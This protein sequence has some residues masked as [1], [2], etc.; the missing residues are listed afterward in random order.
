MQLTNF[1]DVP[2]FTS[3]ALD[4]TL[5]HLISCFRDDADPIKN[6]TEY[7][8]HSL[9]SIIQTESIP[10]ITIFLNGKLIMEKQRVY[11]FVG[12]DFYETASIEDAE[13]IVER[14]LFYVCRAQ[15][16]LNHFK[17]DVAKDIVGIIEGEIPT[18]VAAKLNM[19]KLNMSSFSKV[20]L[21]SFVRLYLLRRAG[22]YTDAFFQNEVLKVDIK[23]SDDIFNDPSFTAT[24]LK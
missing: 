20:A 13:R 17:T 8:K 5:S 4:F 11:S 3:H 24:I 18:E 10:L 1:S 16:Y 9:D 14:M 6:I 23:T 22:E 7:S 19:L 21:G 12:C 15:S 2:D